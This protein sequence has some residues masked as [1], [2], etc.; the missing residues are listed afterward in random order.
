MGAKEAVPFST[1]EAAERFV[2]DKGG[3][4]VNFKDMPEDYVLGDQG[5]PQTGS[6]AENH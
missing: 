5:V 2:A 1:Q 3:R 4:I 6:V